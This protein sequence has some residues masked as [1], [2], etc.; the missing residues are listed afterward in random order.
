MASKHKGRGTFD[1]Q[2]PLQDSPISGAGGQL[3]PVGGKRQRG[4]QTYTALWRNE[5]LRSIGSGRPG[6]K[7]N[8]PVP[9][10]RGDFL[11]VRR[12]E[13]DGGNAAAVRTRNRCFRLVG[14][15]GLKIMN[16]CRPVLQA[17]RQESTVG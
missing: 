4:S 14:R 5:L 16:T 8:T 12:P 10:G 2:I 9:T 17:N 6:R 1:V 7:I 13:R 11:F 15:T 3:I